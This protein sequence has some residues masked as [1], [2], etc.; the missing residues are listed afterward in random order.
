MRKKKFRPGRQLRTLNELWRASEANQWLYL[1]ET[2]KHPTILVSMTIR[3]V[4]GFLRAG[5]IKKA[6]K[7]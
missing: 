5:A 2:P 7:I 6:V 3:T 1:H 4:A